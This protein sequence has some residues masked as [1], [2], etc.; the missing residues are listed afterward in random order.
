MKKELGSF[1]KLILGNIGVSSEYRKVSQQIG[2]FE[3]KT[4]KCVNQDLFD[5]IDKKLNEGK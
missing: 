4:R 5:A 2:R 3:W 1:V